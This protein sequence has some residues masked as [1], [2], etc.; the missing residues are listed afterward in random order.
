[1]S[2]HIFVDGVFKRFKSFESQKGRLLEVIS[3]GYFKRHKSFEVLKGVSF[4]VEPGE[5]VGLIGRNGAG[6][7]TLL[8][9]IA[10]S[11]AP[12]AGSVTIDGTMAALLELGMGFDGEFSGRDNSRLGLQILGASEEQLDDLIDQVEAFAEVGEYFDR[13]MKTYSSGMQV[14][15][16]FSVATAIRPDVLIVDEALSVGDAYFQHKSMAKIREFQALGTTLLF[17]SHDPGAVKTLCDRAILFEGGHILREGKPGEILDYYNAII[18]KDAEVNA[19][20]QLES[21]KGTETRSGN[22]KASIVDAKLYNRHGNEANTFQVG[23]AVTL[24]CHVEYKELIENASFGILIRDRLGNDIFGT[25][26]NL[27]R[28]NLPVKA[29][30]YRFEFTTDLNLGEGHY[31]ITLASHTFDAHIMDNHDW[32]DRACVFQVVPNDGFK[33][34]GVTSLPLEFRYT[35]LDGMAQL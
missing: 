27:L 8:K 4:K 10:G 21:L 23:E 26:T 32:W 20:R 17:V 14:R 16:A 13:P 24:C 33:F 9:I 11:M 19:V 34:I 1:M 2:Y 6:K 3:G 29:G 18:A 25:N 12:T 22:G 15:V 28:K 5:A 7:S 31:S 35:D 30:L